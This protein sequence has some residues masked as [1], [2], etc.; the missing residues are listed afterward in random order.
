MNKRYRVHSFIYQR[1][2][3]IHFIH[4]L[5]LQ[6]IEVLDGRLVAGIQ[7][8]HTS[9]IDDLWRQVLELCT[10]K[11]KQYEQRIENI[12]PFT[13][14]RN[15]FMEC[16]KLAWMSLPV[17]HVCQDTGKNSQKRNQKKNTNTLT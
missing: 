9:C 16:Y 6:H 1:S 12:N 17:E 5:L 11:H 4:P 2:D 3:F 7:E 13:A 14:M 10:A 8:H 15:D